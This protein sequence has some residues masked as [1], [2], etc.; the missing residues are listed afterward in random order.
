[1]QQGLQAFGLAAAQMVNG[2]VAGDGEQPGFKTPAGIVL[3]ALLEDAN[4]RLLKK[5]LRR[6][7]VSRKRPQVAGQAAAA[8]ARFAGLRLPS[9]SQKGKDCFPF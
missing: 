3:V 1:M 4:P 5:V 7:T 8:L 9:N 2:K 6:L